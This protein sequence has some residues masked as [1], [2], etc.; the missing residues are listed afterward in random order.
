VSIPPFGAGIFK[1]SGST[2]PMGIWKQ[3]KEQVPAL[4]FIVSMSPPGYPS[5]WLRPRR[6]G[7]RFARQDP[8]SSTTSIGLNCR[9]PAVPMLF[10][11]GDQ[12]CRAD[13]RKRVYTA[14]RLAKSKCET[15]MKLIS[16]MLFLS[17]LILVLAKGARAQNKAC[18]LASRDELQSLLGAK[19]SEM[20]GTNMPGGNAA[21]CMGQTPTS[22]VTLRLA[23]RSEQGAGAEAAGIEIAKKM[24][25]QVDVKTFGPVT[26]STVIPPASLAEH[27]FN[28]TCS[29]A[30]KTDVAAIEVTAKIQKDMIPIDKLR[31]LAEKMMER[32]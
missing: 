27:G 12:R 2:D 28:T 22:R 21:I 10:L 11:G 31:P 18:A 23:K 4:P 7:F 26:C 8:C 32:F 1:A 9:L 19:V 29:I 24:G 6:A 16:S 20:K 17:V 25:A 30:K 15:R 14:W 5:A 3:R 13:A